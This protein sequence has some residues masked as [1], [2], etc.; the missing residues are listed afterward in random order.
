MRLTRRAAAREC[1]DA[2]HVGIFVLQA[3]GHFAYTVKSV[4]NKGQTAVVDH[5]TGKLQ[6]P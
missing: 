4:R 1:V 2:Q 6:G 3:N 5:G